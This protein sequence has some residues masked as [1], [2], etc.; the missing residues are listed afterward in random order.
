MIVR[1]VEKAGADFSQIDL[2][3]TTVGPGAF[4][5]LRLGLSA[6]RAL[7]LSLDR[8]VVGLS[9]FAALAARY[10]ADHP[11][12]KGALAVILET[13]RA[14]FYYQLIAASDGRDLTPHAAGTAEEAVAAIR[15]AAQEPVTLIGDALDRFAAAHA[16]DKVWSRVDGYE[17]TDPCVMARLAADPAF[18]LS[19]E[20]IYLR[21]AD[22]SRPKR[23]LR[24]IVG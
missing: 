19:P 13:K 6:A 24:E 7:G 20:P 8:P 21:G 2:I 9:T 10:R 18:C 17:L 14:D 5:G 15:E 23:A 4:T 22:V 16:P 3:A 1:V 11:G 12:A